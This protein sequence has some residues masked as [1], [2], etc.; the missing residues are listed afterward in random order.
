MK[1]L[2]FRSSPL[3]PIAPLYSSDS[4]NS[5]GVAS[6]VVPHPSQSPGGPLE[7]Q[8]NS[9]TIA[10]A[11]E[12][13]GAVVGRGG[14]NIMEISQVSGARIKISDRGDFI[15][16]TSDRKVT[17]TGSPEAIRAAEALIMQNEVDD[18]DVW[19]GSTIDEASRH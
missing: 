2:M 1:P 9:V 15:S 3:A 14:R 10:I 18:H 7:G 4:S 5:L 8:S 13:I 19:G 17:I 12:H 16:G 11:D 6:P